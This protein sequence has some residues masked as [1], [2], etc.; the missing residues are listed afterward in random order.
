MAV[1]KLHSVRRSVHESL[2]Y[3]VDENKTRNHTLVRA[4]MCS[5]EPSRAAEQFRAFREQFGSGRS[6]TQA[7]HIILSFAPNE[8]LPERA[9]EIAD[10]LC[11]RLL[12]EQYQYV[13][14][15][16][17]D[18]QHIHAHIVF[19][20]T[21]FVTGKT[22][23]TEHNQ[24]KKSERAWTELRT[25]SDEICKEHHL[26]V[27]QHPEQTKGK[28][29]FEW[30]MNRQGL[31]WKARL[32][33]AI[34]QVIME[35]KNFEDFLK[36][37]ADFGILA[38]YYPDH[39]IDLKFMLAEQKENNPRAKM[40][41]AKTLGWFY[42]TEQ[43]KNRIAQYHGVMTYVPKTKV[44]SEQQ[45]ENRFIQ[46]AIDRGN[47]KVASIAKNII[48]EYGVEPEQIRQIA[49]S[50][51]A[52]SRHI[53]SELN[54]LQTEIE[55]LKIKLKILKK[56]RKLKVYGEKLKTLDGRQAKK[57][58]K[59]YN[60]ELSEYEEIRK[61]VLEFYPSG[62]IPK[63]E[64]LEKKIS[65]L[66]SD[67]SAKNAKFRQADKKARELANAQ[68]TIEEYLRQEQSQDHQKKKRNDLE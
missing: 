58:R 66:E 6:T 17:E 24:G 27:I 31:S 62:H 20:N 65:N 59:E 67:L 33:Y 11:H 68:Q 19:N 21:N 5:T 60:A 44:R 61:Q 37:C 57:Y 7:Q 47:M 55:D 23:E 52:H 3:I 41:R 12:K 28:S 32:K 1:T 34:D 35:S 42:E 49:V 43:I 13:L 8:I 29:H 26:S 30:D 15:V 40:T 2:E 46:D 4:F 54:S 39:K 38:E 63:V 22:F 25:I 48:A 51:Y 53:L 14:A 50:E 56:Y 36:K 18:H 9:M 45:S 16:H 64:N 10:E